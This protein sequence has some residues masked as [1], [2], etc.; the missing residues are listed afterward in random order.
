MS[1]PE[2]EKFEFRAGSVLVLRQ[3]AKSRGTDHRKSV[4]ISSHFGHEFD[5]MRQALAGFVRVLDLR[6]SR[7]VCILA[8]WLIGSRVFDDLFDLDVGEWF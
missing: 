5:K 3:L 7:K 4:V 8:C 6:G 1:W 2:C